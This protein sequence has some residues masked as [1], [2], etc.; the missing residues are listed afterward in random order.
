MTTVFI[1][2]KREKKYKELNMTDEK[3]RQ[4]SFLKKKAGVEPQSVEEKAVVEAQPAEPIQEIVQ[5][6]TVEKKTAE[7]ARE[8]DS[9]TV[10]IYSI[11]FGDAEEKIVQP[12]V[13]PEVKNEEPV[14]AEK[15]VPEPKEKKKKGLR[16]ILGI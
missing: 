6:E 12:A 2:N 5:P 9:F 14:Q 13:E 4:G 3:I 8:G 11:D 15:I 1:D 16:R 10:P 7:P